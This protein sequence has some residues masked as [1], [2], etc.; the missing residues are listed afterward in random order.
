MKMKRFT[1]ET[2]STVLSAQMPTRTIASEIL[3]GTKSEGRIVE[4]NWIV[5]FIEI[6]EQGVLIIECIPP[7]YAR[8]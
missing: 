4:E 6:D 8:I 3:K 7:E 1:R 5:S 2:L